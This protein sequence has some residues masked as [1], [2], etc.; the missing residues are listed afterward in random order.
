VIESGGKYLF[1][2]G[3]SGALADGSKMENRPAL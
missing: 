2:N 1:T 3:L